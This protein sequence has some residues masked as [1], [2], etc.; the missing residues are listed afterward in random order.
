[1]EKHPVYLILD[2]DIHNLEQ[3]KHYIELGQPLVKKFGGEYL[4]RGGNIEEV[5]TQLWKPAR[6]VLIKF[7]DKASALNW[8][9][10]EE[11]K[12]ISNL[13]TDNSTSTLIFVDGVPE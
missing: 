2:I 12:K 8:Y 4:I 10:S 7:P 11:Y 3:Y 9:N 6:I 5:D 13:R 1:M